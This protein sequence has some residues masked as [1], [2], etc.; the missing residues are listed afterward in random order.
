MSQT[1][2]VLPGDG[3]GPE[4]VRQGHKL[5]ESLVS[6]FGLNHLRVEEGLLGGVAVDEVGVPHL[7]MSGYRTVRLPGGLDPA[8]LAPLAAAMSDEG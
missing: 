3:I 2:L 7:G 4:I 1:I 6:D 8:D 5:F